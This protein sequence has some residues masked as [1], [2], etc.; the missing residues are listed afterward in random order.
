MLQRAGDV[1]GH[2]L[3]AL[4]Q[5]GHCGQAD[6]V[7]GW[8]SFV[9][10]VDVVVRA[11]RRA[12]R[13]AAVLHEGDGVAS[14]AWSDSVVVA[15]GQHQRVVRVEVRALLHAVATA[16]SLQRV[17]EVDVGVVGGGVLSADGVVDA[18]RLVDL[19]GV[20][21]EVGVD[22]AVDHGCDVGQEQQTAE[23]VAALSVV[24]VH[25]SRL[26]ILEVRLLFLIVFSTHLKNIL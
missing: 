8:R 22:S 23:H 11:G 12:C 18:H 7:E 24:L 25:G 5:H 10:D 1:V 4:A 6:A 26:N 21:V 3:E 2:V 20:A 15:L 14:T 9:A 13:P 19:V 17:V 16:E